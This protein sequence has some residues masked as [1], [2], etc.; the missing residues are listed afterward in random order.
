MGGLQ[1]LQRVSVVPVDLVNFSGS[2]CSRLEE[3]H[4][5]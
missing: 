4:G 3:R 2:R 5:G 1:K